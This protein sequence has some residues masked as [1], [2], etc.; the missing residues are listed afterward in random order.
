MYTYLHE[1]YFAQIEVICYDQ[2]SEI[3][4]GQAFFLVNCIHLFQQKGLYGQLIFSENQYWIK[5]KEL[6]AG[7][8]YACVCV[9]VHA[10]R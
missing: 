8:V 7:S 5:G 3:H 6:D 10:R 1:C 9:C 2:T 4:F